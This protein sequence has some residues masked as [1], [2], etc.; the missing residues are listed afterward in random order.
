VLAP[1]AVVTQQLK[2]TWVVITL[3]PIVHASPQKLQLLAMFST[4]IIDMIDCQEIRLGF[5]TAFAL[6]A[7]FVQNFRLDESVIHST[8]FTLP[9]AISMI[10]FSRLNILTLCA[11]VTVAISIRRLFAI[12]RQA[13]RTRTTATRLLDHR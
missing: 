9:N 8:A 13:Q 11:L 5:V 12:G 3:E 6:V 10:T 4:I 7:I 1:I 2:A